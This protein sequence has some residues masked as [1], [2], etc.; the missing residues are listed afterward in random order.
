MFVYGIVVGNQMRLHIGEILS[1]D[2][3][4]KPQPFLMSV[5]VRPHRQDLVFQMNEFRKVGSRS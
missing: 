5:F 1:I 2:L 3:R 4:E